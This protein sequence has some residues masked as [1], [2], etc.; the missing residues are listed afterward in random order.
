MLAVS[1]ILFLVWCA[2]DAQAPGRFPTNLRQATFQVSGPIPS[3]RVTLESGLTRISVELDDLPVLAAPGPTPGFA[4]AGWLSFLDAD[5]NRVFVTTGVFRIQ[6][7]DGIDSIHRIGPARFTYDSDGTFQ[8][9]SAGVEVSPGQPLPPGESLNA[10][11]SFFLA[12]ETDP[13]DAA[14]PG[15][16]HPLVAPDTLP[17]TPGSVD[18][19]VPVNVGLTSQGDFSELRGEA[20]LSASTGEYKLTFSS[21]P[22]LSRTSPPFDVGLIYQAWFVDD[23]TS[24]PRYQSIARFAP[25]A[26]G[27][28]TVLGAITPGD[29]DGDRAPE[30]IDFERILISLEPDGISAQQ[31][32]GQGLDTSGEIFPIIP[33]RMRLP[34]PNQ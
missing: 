3:G 25:N 5:T 24:P 15:Y 23:D 31:P 21:L 27:D 6:A 34:E 19:I 30:P 14:G 10:G 1:G 32:V 8:L 13:D 33:Y 26:I 4:Y 16:I 20:Q 17:G 7:T 18:L 11:M 29:L 12:I 28:A 9:T 2:C 22:V